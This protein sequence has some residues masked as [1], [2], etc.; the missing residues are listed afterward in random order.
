VEIARLSLV[1][2]RPDDAIEFAQEALKAQPGLAEATMILARAML[3]KGDA[4]SAEPHV[5]QLAK[6]LPQSASAQAELGQFH[7]MK[8][9]ARNARVA[10]ER[11]LTIDPKNLEAL[12]GLTAID[13]QAGHV[14]NARARVDARLIAQ[15]DEPRLLLLAGRLFLALGDGPATER[16]LRRIIEVD[17]AQFDAYALLGQ[18]YASHQRLDEARV[19]FERIARL[20]PKRAV[21]AETLVG[22]ILQIQNKP[23]EAQAR[24]EKVLALDPRA[25]VAANNLAWIY[26]EGGGN[27][28]VALGLAQT[29]KSL[30]AGSSEVNDTLGWVYYKKGLASLAV[31]ILRESVDKSPRNAVYHYHLGLAY[32][33]SGN[34]GGARKALERA[35]VL[36]PK[37]SG[38]A[39]AKRVL[40]TLAG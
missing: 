22:I 24:Y 9:D 28:D 39:E 13:I 26:A 20:L 32:A 40:A 10:F 4:G 14:A 15:P 11:A 16:T 34:S 6:Q 7:A 35:L 21:G 38:S 18:F 17:P 31:P 36:D 19:E 23:A 33:K 8:G 27:L 25:A 29:A 1:T 37:F 5:K 30:L 2:G 3:T 12:A